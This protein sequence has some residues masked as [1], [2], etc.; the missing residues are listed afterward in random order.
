MLRPTKQPRR[1]ILNIIP[2]PK[3]NTQL[4]TSHLIADSKLP[5]G[6]RLARDNHDLRKAQALRYAVFNVE[7][8]EGLSASHATGLDADP[9]DNIC[10]HLIVEHLPTHTVVG[11]YRLQTGETAARGLGYYSAQEFDFRPYEP[12]RSR[13]VELGRACVAA[14]HRNLVV[15]G[16]LWRGIA[17]YARDHGARYLCGCSSINTTD[18]AIGASVYSELCRRHLVE[19]ALRTQ[20]TGGFECPLDSLAPEPPPIPKL[21]RAYLG[22]GATI[23]GPPALDGTFGTI[24]FLT[25][26]DLHALPAVVRQR[27]L[28]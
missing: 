5:Y 22:I 16:L 2:R 24:D 26:V 19:P 7:L 23:C 8:S 17:E 27:L 25:F 9:F 1:R 3:M 6:L 28:G 21:L 12:L 20:P 18:P 11:T 13:M 15:L 4:T 14:S 10:D